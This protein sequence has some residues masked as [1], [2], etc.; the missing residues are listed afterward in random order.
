V[1]RPDASD[2]EGLRSSVDATVFEPYMAELAL[3]RGLDKD[4]L[5]V[6][7]IEKRREEIMVDHLYRDSIMTRVWVTPAERQ[8]Y[9]RDHLNGYVTFASVQFGAI[10]RGS[11]AGADSVAARLRAG[12]SP[13]SILRED[14]LRGVTSGSIQ[15]RRQ[16]EGGT[17]YHKLLFE[18]LKPGQVAVEGPDKSGDWLVLQLLSFDPG[19]QLSYEEAQHYVDESLQNIKSERLLKAFLA[20]HRKR[21]HVEAHP[22]LVMRIRFVDPS[23]EE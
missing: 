10:V 18:E 6:A 17:P 23:L 5:A 11:K 2:F 19:R 20:R 16:N 22:K 7:M 9:Y 15:Q 3:R 12:V 13:A 4:S 8:K 21:F 1:M 14:S